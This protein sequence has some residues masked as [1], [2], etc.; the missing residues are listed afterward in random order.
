[1]LVITIDR[2]GTRGAVDRRVADSSGVNLSGSATGP[3]AE[4]AAQH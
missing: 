4:E 3:G 1:M 2:P